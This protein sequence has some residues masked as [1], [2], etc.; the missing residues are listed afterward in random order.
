MQ[1]PSNPARPLALTIHG[2]ARWREAAAAVQTVR[3]LVTFVRPEVNPRV[4]PP[5][6]LSKNSVQDDSADSLA[7]PFGNDEERVKETAAGYDRSS[8]VLAMQSPGGRHS[9]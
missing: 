2:S 1:T 8:P 5:L 7:P 6:R 3:A 4:V 9:D